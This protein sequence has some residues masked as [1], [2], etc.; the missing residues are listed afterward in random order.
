MDGRSSEYDDPRRADERRLS[1]REAM[2][3]VAWSTALAT[4]A[5]TASGTVAADG[6]VLDEYA[7]AKPNH[8]II[9]DYGEDATTDAWLDYYRPLLD[10][11]H[12][13]HDNHPTIRGWRVTSNESDVETEAA[14]YLSE[15][16]VQKDALT[17]TSHSGDHEWIY[18]FV[19]PDSGEV[20]S[21]SY[22]FYHWLRGFI[23]EPTVYDQ[24]GGKHVMFTAAP[25]YHNHVPRTDPGEGAL[26][27]VHPLGDYDTLTGPFYDILKNGMNQS[28][29][30]GAVHEPWRL[31]PDGS[32]DAWWRQ[33]GGKWYNRLI[34][35]AFARVG[36]G[37]GIDFRGSGIADPGDASV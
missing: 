7:D 18:V 15:Y 13:P 32:L 11:R 19:D 26:M 6:S 34:V 4:T 28:L 37:L 25:T 29:E 1:R 10:L 30:P 14:V 12:V 22:S 24:N 33:D 16:A 36:F 23:R 35:D 3:K 27:D 20:Q 17:L 5:T 8:V 2:Q 31:S 9:T 21:V